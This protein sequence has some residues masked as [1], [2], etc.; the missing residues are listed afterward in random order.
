MDELKSSVSIED[1]LGACVNTYTVPDFDRIHPQC[2]PARQDF[3]IE[4]G[5]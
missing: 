3:H 4:C 5:V 1:N 2:G